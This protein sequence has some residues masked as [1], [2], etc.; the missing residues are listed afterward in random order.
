MGL[1]G[2]TDEET[3]FK[4]VN[5]IACG[6][7]YLHSRNISHRDLKLENVL[8]GSDGKW[9]ICDLGSCTTK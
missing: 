7:E 3:L 1:S 9:K 8:M 6:L 4:V 2:I 5:D